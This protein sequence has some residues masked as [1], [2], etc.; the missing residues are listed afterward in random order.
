MLRTM[1]PAKQIALKLTAEQLAAID[2]YCAQTGRERA[3]VIRRATLAAI[4]R[5]DLVD[6]MP[7]VGRPKV[8]EKKPQKKGAKK[9]SRKR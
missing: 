5:Q 4:G 6:A 8:A 7:P 1:A 3:D 2:E 9:A